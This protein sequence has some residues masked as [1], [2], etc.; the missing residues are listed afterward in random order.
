[1]KIK[2]IA[3]CIILIINCITFNISA[4]PVNIYLDKELCNAKLVE[5]VII[6]YYNAD[7]VFY[8]KMQSPQQI[9]FAKLKRISKEYR[10][11]AHGT[12]CLPNVNDTVVIVVNYSNV[13]SLFAVLENECYRFW[14]PYFP[15]NAVFFHFHSP[16]M[17]IP[18]N[19]S[20]MEFWTVLMDIPISED[21]KNNS[22][23]DGCL[24]PKQYLKS[25]G[26]D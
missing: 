12:G 23:E 16:A 18:G 10:K 13:V 22:C 14:Y 24:L 19:K 6:K 1:M 8:A 4:K 21:D 25:Y 20:E 5:V 9:Q 15:F 11:F 26:R 7:T 2:Q 3:I 17:K